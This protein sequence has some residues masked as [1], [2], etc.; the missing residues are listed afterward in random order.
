MST[1]EVE[2]V[3]LGE[4]NCWRVRDGRSE[5]L[6]AQ[7][8]AQVLSY[9][10]G[11]DHPLIWLNPDAELKKGRPI[12]AGVPV[13]WPWFGN[14]AR[15][16]TGVQAMREGE[17]AAPAH[18]LVRAM[19]WKLD[20]IDQ[21]NGTVA[22]NFSLPE[23][24]GSLP[25]WP[26]AASLKMQIELGEDLHIQL[27]TLNLG[28]DRVI[29]SQAL[30]TYFAVSDVRQVAVDEVAGLE[31]IETLENWEERQQTGPLTVAGETDRIYLNTPGRLTIADPGWKRRILITPEGSKSAVIWNPWIARA[32]ALPD[33]ADDGWKNM[34]CIETANVMDDVMGLRPGSSHTLGVR[35]SSEA[36]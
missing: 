22:L 19:D 36:L 28:R 13:C 7:Q 15:N 24:D 12:R 14:L 33:L 8:G 17:D 10:V 9:Q 35:I 32:A 25:T 34:F 4:L 29:I 11:S 18:G 30:H 5:L 2:S 27:T 6:V 31:Y 21:A 1:P 23:A 3:T 20:G 26:H 16:P